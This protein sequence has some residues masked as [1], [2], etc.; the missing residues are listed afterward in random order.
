MTILN[1]ELGRPL[2]VVAGTWNPAIF[3]HK[4]IAINLFGKAIGESVTLTQVTPSSGPTVTYFGD[5]G[6]A[7]TSRRIELFANKFDENA[8]LE[9]EN[10]C[11]KIVELLPHTP[12]GS[13]GINYVFSVQEPD[14]HLI[15][16]LKTH[17]L[18]EKHFLI[19][20]Q[21]FTAQIDYEGI[22]L[23]LIRNVSAGQ[24]EINLNFHYTAAGADAVKAIVR[25]SLEKMYGKAKEVISK[26]YGEY[27]IQSRGHVFP[28][29]ANMGRGT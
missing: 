26:I 23:N 3:Q 10:T 17:E 19:V 5:I 4:W 6:I 14:Q 16:K 24:F 20:E 8:R 29:D 1:L 21:N 11:V 2:I 13:I 27:E 28:I 18:L 12:I 25:G 7:A 9:L 22:R 15:D